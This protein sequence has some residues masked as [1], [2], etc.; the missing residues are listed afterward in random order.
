MVVNSDG[1]F[2]LIEPP[3]SDAEFDSLPNAAPAVAIRERVVGK[4]RKNE[5]TAHTDIVSKLQGGLHIAVPND[6]ERHALEVFMLGAQDS[7]TWTQG[8]V[9]AMRTWLNIG[10]AGTNE[11]GKPIYAPGAKF[12]DDWK[13]IKAAILPQPAEVVGK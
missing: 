2:R 12:L 10:T 11:Q 8:Q 6:D 9:M 13:V 4:K 1:S 5:T 3:A 7:A